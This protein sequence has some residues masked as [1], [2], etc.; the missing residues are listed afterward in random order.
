MKIIINY[1]EMETK[2]MAARFNE[3]NCWLFAKVNKIGKTL[4]KLSKRNREKIQIRNVKGGYNNK[5]HMKFRGLLSNVAK[6]VFQ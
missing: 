3:T 4:G 2:V 5:C 6:S 1:C